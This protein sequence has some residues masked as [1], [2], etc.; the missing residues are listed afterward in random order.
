[1]EAIVVA[2]DVVGGDGFE[3]LVVVAIGT[4]G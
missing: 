3:A 1:M 4:A 2:V